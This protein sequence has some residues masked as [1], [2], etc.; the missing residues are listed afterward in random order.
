M[1]WNDG[2]NSLAKI[3][4]GGDFLGYYYKNH[5]IPTPLIG[6]DALFMLGFWWIEITFPKVMKGNY[7]II[8]G[9]P[10]SNTA[11]FQVFLDGKLTDYHYDGP[12]GGNQTIAKAEFLTT[13][14]HKI[15]IVPS[16]YGALYWDFVQFVPVN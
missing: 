13:S 5:D 2:Q 11:S 6:Y 1:K 7:Q 15:K 16:I 8:Y 12:R 10:W 4:F 14:E 3:K 9:S